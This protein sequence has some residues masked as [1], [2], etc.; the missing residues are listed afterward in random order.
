MGKKTSELVR[1]VKENGPI[2]LDWSVWTNRTGKQLMQNFDSYAELLAQSGVSTIALMTDS[3]LDSSTR[4]ST[5]S[6]SKYD[7]NP[8]LLFDTCYKIQSAGF[9][10]IPVSWVDTSKRE[11]DSFFDGTRK[12]PGFGSLIVDSN[13]KRGEIDWEGANDPSDSNVRYFSEKL[14][15][16]KRKYGYKLDVDT[17]AARVSKREPLHLFGAADGLVVQMYSTYDPD[18]PER[19]WGAP[20][21]PGNRQVYGDRRVR[22]YVAAFPQYKFESVTVGIACYS[23]EYP[24]D[25]G[26]A[27]G[28]DSIIEAAATA[29]M[30]GYTRLRFWKLKDFV[31]NA[32]ASVAVQTINSIVAGG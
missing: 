10:T 25:A 16:D 27:S 8:D 18:E 11:I 26:G 7:N 15:S 17:H 30:L 28:V 20:H 1:F 3:Q 21:G 13:S 24:A 6:L 5:Y 32:Y 22:D 29:I 4:A 9:E 23:Q 31:Q 19:F 12:L 14:V 2:D